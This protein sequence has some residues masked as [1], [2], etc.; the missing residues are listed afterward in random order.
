VADD[1]AIV[2]EVAWVARRARELSRPGATPTSAELAEYDERCAALLRA[3]GYHDG[4]GDDG[5]TT[6]PPVGTDPTTDPTGP[7]TGTT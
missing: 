7:T 1:L 2:R 3:V 6:T 5:P 4:G